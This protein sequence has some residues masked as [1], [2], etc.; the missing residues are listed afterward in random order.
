M[1]NI[2]E[3]DPKGGRPIIEDEEGNEKPQVIELK[4]KLKKT[5]RDLIPTKI[6]KED[7]KVDFFTEKIFEKIDT[8]DPVKNTAWTEIIISTIQDKEN[9]IEDK[10]KDNMKTLLSFK[11]LNKI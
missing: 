5:I 10:V 9:E 6:D 11:L 8:E 2:S 4:K 3:D 1:K 7:N